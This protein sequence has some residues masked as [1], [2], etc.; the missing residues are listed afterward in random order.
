MAYLAPIHR[1]SSVRHALRLNFF[2]ADEECV[3]VAKANRLELY[4]QTPNGLS[5][6]HSK[7]IY[8][9]VTMLQ[10]LRPTSSPIDHLF[11]GTDRNTFF[12]VSWDPSSKQLK[13]EKSYVDLADKTGRDSQSMDRCLIDPM[14]RFMVLDLFEGILTV[15]PF[16]YA[17]MGN[18]GEMIA[19]E[20]GSPGEPIT[21]RIPELFVRSSAFLHRRFPPP[22][23]DKPRLVLLCD[24]GDEKASVKIRS[25]TYAPEGAS[26]QGYAEFEEEL[27]LQFD[28]DPSAS[29]LI[30][31]PAPAYGFFILSETSITYV[32]DD[33]YHAT[34]E[35]LQHATIFV[36]W[37]QID[38]Q[39]WLLADDFGSLYFLMVHLDADSVESWKLDLLGETPRASV[40][41][42]L[43]GGYAFVGS[44]QGDSQVIRIHENSLEVVQTMTNLAPILDFTIMDMGNRAG[45]GGQTNEFSSGQARLVTGSGAFQDGS[46][47]SVRSGVGMEE[48]GNLGQMDHITQLFSLSSGG[49][50]GKTDILVASFFDETRAFEFSPEGEVEEAE[51]FRGFDLSEGTLLAANV[52]RDRLLQVIRSAA[53]LTDLESGMSMA[54]WTP[55]ADQS[56]IAASTDAHYLAISVGGVDL[57][58]LDISKELD[59]SAQKTFGADSQIACLDIPTVVSGVLIVGFWHGAAISIFNIKNLELIHTIR[60]SDEAIAVP[61]TVLLTQILPEQP[62]TLFV[63]MADGNVVTYTVDPSTFTASGR[64]S[65]ILGTQQANLRAIPKGNGLFNVFAMCE[66]PSLIYGAEGR[67]IYSAVTAEYATCV[68][69]FDTAAFPGAVAISSDAA[70]K[71]AHVDSERRTHVQTLHVGETV[72]RVAYSPIE[73]AFGLGTIKRTLEN[74]IEI[75]QSHFVLADEILFEKLDTYKLN[76]DE[77]VECVARM[78]VQGGEDSEAAECFIVGTSYLE[79]AQEQT[80]RGRI[81][82]FTVT[83][84]RRL[85]KTAQIGLRGACRALAVMDGKIVAALVKTV[86][87]YTLSP[88]TLTKLAAYRTAT[89]PISIAVTGPHIAIADIMK[90]VSVVRYTPGTAGEPD[91]LTETARHFAVAWGTAVAHVDE[92]TVLESDAE[93]NLTLLKQNTQGVTEDDRRRLEVTAEIR[94]GELVNRIQRIN[95]SASV[96]AV[97]VPRAF[98]ATTEGAIYLF[99][100]IAPGYQDLLMRLQA[101]LAGYVKSAGNVPFNKYRAFRNEVRGA[102]EPFRFV[103]GEL[104]EGFLDL[105][106]GVQERVV[107]GLGVVVEG[108]VER[109]RGLVEGLRRLC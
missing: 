96:D 49:T 67:I 4:A 23:D 7:A 103:D 32:E 20:T 91:T 27:R 50:S 19:V 63:A 89:A 29:H 80:E 105:D 84:A 66:H 9:R 30:P 59:V 92:D 75:V 101:T 88:P 68:C 57:Y 95:V 86:V 43:D 1:P 69:P 18:E 36:T 39:R 107:G 51:D 13:T 11:V 104:V 15:F 41:V 46:L 25:L 79:D 97:V 93:G 22:K 62:P 74:G 56:I 47:R 5:L 44:H 73:K 94:L 109:V 72:R 33:S 8:G 40:L 34:V 58:V 55:P 60:V 64:T 12:A 102:E 99:A 71:I 87:I 81:L 65:T 38:P 77:L 48:I 35:P 26:E 42:Y 54:E 24:D 106:E 70:L 37:T 98:L 76:E 28:V 31:V 78:A 2:K 17:K 100:L 61:R 52:P 82:V 21:V 90:S 14:R 53:Y 3:V 83:P 45:E 6:Q 85:E 10:K 108:G 16:F